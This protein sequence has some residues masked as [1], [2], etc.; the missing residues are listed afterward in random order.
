[1]RGLCEEAKKNIQLEIECVIDEVGANTARHI[2]KLDKICAECFRSKPLETKRCGACGS[3]D[4][5][6]YTCTKEV[7]LSLFKE[8]LHS[9]GYW[10]LSRLHEQSC[11]N[12]LGA[13]PSPAGTQT[14]CGLG[15]TC[16]LMVAKVRLITKLRAKLATIEG[17]TLED[18]DVACLTML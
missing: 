7:R 18:Y 13:M 15:G 16:P 12:F 6:E 2:G 9:Q 11:R 3:S 1:M 5:C 8:W 17:L 4:F 14:P 10:P